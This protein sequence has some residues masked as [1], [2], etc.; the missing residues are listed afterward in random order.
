MRM[1][2][3]HTAWETRWNSLLLCPAPRPRECWLHVFGR[4]QGVDAAIW[5]GSSRPSPASAKTLSRSLR[6]QL[7]SLGGPHRAAPVLTVPVNTS[8]EPT[9]RGA[10]HDVHAVPDISP[11]AGW[12]GCR[13]YSSETTKVFSR[14]QTTGTYCAAVRLR[15]HALR[16]PRPRSRR[17]ISVSVCT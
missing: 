11:R 10:C 1:L 4:Q 7:A 6:Y 13:R 8:F 3:A 17:R 12:P 14:T 16:A 15:L 5:A 9:E 2:S